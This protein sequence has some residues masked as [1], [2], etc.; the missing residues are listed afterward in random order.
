[1]TSSARGLLERTFGGSA[2]ALRRQSIDNPEFVARYA[3]VTPYLLCDCDTVRDRFAEMQRELPTLE[4]YYAVKC[5][6]DPTL[7]RTLLDAG[8]SFEVAS[9][10]ELDMVRAVGADPA[11]TLYSNTVKPPA[12]VSASARAGATRFAFDS[13]G[14]LEK[15]AHEAPGAEVYVRL[16]VDD[17]RSIFP[18][19]RKFGTSVEEALGLMILADRLGLVPM[20]ITFHVGSQCTEPRA[21]AAAIAQSGLLMRRLSTSGIHVSM[22]NIGG[23]FPARYSDEATPFSAIAAVI[24]KE[25]HRLPYLPEHI[26]AEPGRFLVAESATMVTSVIGIEERAG[27]RWVYLDVGGY[28]GLMEA[29]QTG[30]RWKF[31]LSTTADPGTLAPCTVTGP[32]CDSSDTLFYGVNLPLELQVGDRVMIGSAGAYST[33]Y[34]SSFNGFPPPTP[35]FLNAP[36]P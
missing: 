31:P 11:R 16:R 30:G 26:A 24:E 35:L 34:A 18:L 13:R 19:S 33:S 28:N 7:L 25:L 1:M 22:L 15:I 21:W 6:P 36:P 12:H 14:E 4:I 32:S 8:S 9:L 10:F 27:D 2:R 17:S 29:L 3:D 23:G 20:G 5:N